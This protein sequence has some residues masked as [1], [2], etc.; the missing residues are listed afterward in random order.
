VWGARTLSSDAER[1]Y[2][3]V[4]RLLIYVEQ[5]IKKGTAWAVF[6]PNNEATWAKIKASVECFLTQTWKNGMLMGV[7]PQEAFFVNCDRNI[8]MTQNDIDSG[9]LLI[10][11]GVAPIKPAEFLTLRISQLMVHS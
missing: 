1:K 8:T 2:V 7:K 6:E 11:V 5:S 3:S 4:C 9:R 10:L